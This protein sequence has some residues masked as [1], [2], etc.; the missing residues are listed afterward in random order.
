MPVFEVALF[1][2]DTAKEAVLRGL[3]AFFIGFFA[4]VI[5]FSV[6]RTK[7]TE[8]LFDGKV[9]EKKD[10]L[11]LLSA[12]ITSHSLLCSGVAI[13]VPPEDGNFAIPAMWGAVIGLLVYLTLNS[14][15]ITFKEKWHH[16]WLVLDLVK[17]VSVTALA[18]VGSAF[19]FFVRN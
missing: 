19:I 11:N 1:D 3:V 2:G 17:G 15:L 8:L 16:G 13:L 9:L 12:I 18:S 4:D 5:Y 10:Y 14:Y 6:M 7:Y